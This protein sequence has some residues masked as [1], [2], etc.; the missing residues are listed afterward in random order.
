MGCQ[1]LPPSN[2]LTLRPPIEIEAQQIVIVLAV[3]RC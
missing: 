3:R 2:K 1:P